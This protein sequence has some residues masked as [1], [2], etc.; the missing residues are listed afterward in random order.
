M[1]ICL[2]WMK[3]RKIYGTKWADVWYFCAAE[4]LSEALVLV[5]V[6]AGVR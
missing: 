3:H 4:T 5:A 2:M 6:I 1:I